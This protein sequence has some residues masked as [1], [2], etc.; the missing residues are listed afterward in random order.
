MGNPLS[1]ASKGGLLGF[2]WETE[3]FIFSELLRG[4]ETGILI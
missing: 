2:L 4:K 1:K 3:E